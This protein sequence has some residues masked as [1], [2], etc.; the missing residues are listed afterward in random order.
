MF[1]QN[2]NA[3]EYHLLQKKLLFIQKQMIDI[4]NGVVAT[5]EKMEVLVKI[6]LVKRLMLM[7][8]YLRQAMQVIYVKLNLLNWIKIRYV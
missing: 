4:G 8:F 6:N 7:L 2:S 1:Y 5:N 3:S